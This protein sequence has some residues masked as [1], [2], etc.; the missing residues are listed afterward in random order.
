MAGALL[1][2]R[3]NSPQR[4]CQEGQR[5]ME[6]D[7]SVQGDMFSVSPQAMKAA[8]YALRGTLISSKV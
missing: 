8:T 6:V 5:E 2:E 1:V 4:E 7:V 3:M